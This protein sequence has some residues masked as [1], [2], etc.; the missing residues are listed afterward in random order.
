M[1]WLRL[2]RHFFERPE[3]DRFKDAEGGKDDIITYCLLLLA[4]GD[5]VPCD[6][7]KLSELIGVPARNIKATLNRFYKAGLVKMEDD[8][9]CLP[10][11]EEVAAY[12]AEIG[13]QID[14]KKFY[15]WY[16]ASDFKYK[17]LPMDWKAKMR[18]WTAKERPKAKTNPFLGLMKEQT[19]EYN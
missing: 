14:T 4:G 1:T 7:D 3:L 18:E 6:K 16:A 9:R 15:D 13:S 2:D 19:V 17:G 10:S 5:K 12:A 11:F 8:G